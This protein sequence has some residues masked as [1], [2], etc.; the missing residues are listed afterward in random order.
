MTFISPR[1]HSE[2]TEKAVAVD[3]TQDRRTGAV[4]STN[5]TLLTLVGR[6]SD[7]IGSLQEQ[8]N[9]LT[10][11]QDF[12]RRTEKSSEQWR[13]ARSKVEELQLRIEDA[14]AAARTAET[15][16]VTLDSQLRVATDRES[17]LNGKLTEQEDKFHQ[18]REELF[19]RVE[20][21]AER[22]LEEYRNSLAGS[23][24][25]LVRGVPARGSSVS[26]GKGDVLLARLYQLVDLLESKGIRVM[27]TPGGD[28]S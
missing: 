23:L 16:V 12:L 15:K 27:P 10:E 20:T 13:I 19:R 22:R 24:R 3:T 26:G 14:E 2:N 18:E 28:A 6:L 17:A 4:A 8:I 5:P 21:N 9:T 1:E 25:E 7:W 11:I